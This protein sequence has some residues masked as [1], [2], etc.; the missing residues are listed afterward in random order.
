MQRLSIGH[1][2][3]YYNMLTN[4]PC[5]FRAVEST[6]VGIGTMYY[7]HYSRLEFSIKCT[8]YYYRERAEK[9]SGTILCQ[10]FFKNL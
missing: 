1:R 4:I 9:N 10:F 3:I 5:A 8:N 7:A 2:Y 6:Y